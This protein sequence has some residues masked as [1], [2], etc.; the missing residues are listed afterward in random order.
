MGMYAITPIRGGWKNRYLILKKNEPNAALLIFSKK[1]GL[2]PAVFDSKQ[3]AE[4]FLQNTKNQLLKHKSAGK[5]KINPD[6]GVPSPASNSDF[7]ENDIVYLIKQ[8]TL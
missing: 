5:I 4:L 8:K 2:C 3:E 6:E 1:A 7:M